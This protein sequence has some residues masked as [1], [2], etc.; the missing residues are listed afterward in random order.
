MLRLHE[1]WWQK[2]S[3]QKAPANDI[4]CARSPYIVWIVWSLFSPFRL[5]KRASFLEL[6]AIP[7]EIGELLL[8]QVALVVSH[9]CCTRSGALC[10]PA[11]PCSEAGLPRCKRYAL[12]RRP[13]FL[14][15]A[16]CGHQ[17]SARLCLRQVLS[18]SPRDQCAAAAV[19]SMSTAVVMLRG[20]ACHGGRSRGAKTTADGER[21]TERVQALRLAGFCAP[22][23]L[24]RAASK[25]PSQR[26][27]LIMHSSFVAPAGLAI[28]ISKH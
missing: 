2:C 13:G 16:A 10:G 9:N 18:D 17:F 8:L 21:R 15:L 28:S 11:F 5:I 23:R 7:L 1:N 4:C 19:M 6:S 12:P 20:L 3:G 14:A 22:H 25:T 24:K 27:A 26:D